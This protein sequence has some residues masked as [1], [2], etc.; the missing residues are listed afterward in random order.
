MNDSVD[1]K[2]ETFQSFGKKSSND[3]TKSSVDVKSNVS[4]LNVDDSAMDID[5]VQSNRITNYFSVNH[6]K[7]KSDQVAI[8]E[9]VRQKVGDL[10]IQN[11]SSMDEETEDIQL[12]Y[13]EESISDATKTEVRNT[14]P[15]I[16]SIPIACHKTPKTP[17]RV[18]LITL[19]SPKELKK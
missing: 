4:V 18:Q 16:N 10:Q 1:L 3:A 19:S 2:Q 7:Q 8:E 13:N 17:R 6:N 12:V 5:L 11:K 15:K 14:P 9:N